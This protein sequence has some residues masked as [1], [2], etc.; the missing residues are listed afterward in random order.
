MQIEKFIDMLEQR[1]DEKA[2]SALN[3]AMIHGENVPDAIKKQYGF[4]WAYVPEK[5]N[6]LIGLKKD[7]DDLEHDKWEVIAFEPKVKAAAVAKKGMAKEFESM[8]EAIDFTTF[9]EVSKSGDMN[10]LKLLELIKDLLENKTI[11]V[12]QS[13]AAKLKTRG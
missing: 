12:L 3:E 4:K 13:T 8:N 2:A 6:I 7:S 10:F 5:Y 11:G 9:T 1:V